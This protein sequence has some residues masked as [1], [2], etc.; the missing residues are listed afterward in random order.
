MKITSEYLV[1]LLGSVAVPVI[2]IVLNFVVRGVKHWYYT[3][4]TDFLVAQMTFSFSSAILWKDMAPYIHNVYIR[5][6][7]QGIFVILGL[8]ILIAWV[9]TAEY[10]EKEVNNSIRRGVKSKSFPQGK[11]FISWTAVIVFFAVEIMSFISP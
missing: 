3:A 11:L 2:I 4:G 6:A 9:L 1:F 5:G 8:V 10:V 7:A